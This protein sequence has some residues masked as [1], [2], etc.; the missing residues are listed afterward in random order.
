MALYEVAWDLRKHRVHAIAAVLL[1]V[2][3]V[4]AGVVPVASPSPMRGLAARDQWRRFSIFFITNGFILGLFPSW[5]PRMSS[6]S[7]TGRGTCSGRERPRSRGAT[8]SHWA[9][10]AKRGEGIPE[11]L[12]AHRRGTPSNLSC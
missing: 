4:M 5:K 12:H 3:V 11:R 7:Q 6:T 9:N 1:L 10:V 2:I 8:R